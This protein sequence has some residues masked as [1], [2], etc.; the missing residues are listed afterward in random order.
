MMRMRETDIYYQ[1]KYLKTCKITLLLAKVVMDQEL[2]RFYEKKL[3]GARLPAD[4]LNELINS[5]KIIILHFLRHLGC[6]YCKHAVDQLY[7]Y[8]QEHPNFPPVI[9]IHQSNEEQASLFFQ[10]HY[11]D[12]SYITDTDLSLYNLFGIRK[13]KGMHLFD[14]RM[15]FK[16]FKL[17][18]LGYTNRLGHGN[19]Y[20]LSGTFVFLNG[21][22]VWSHR[23]KRAGEEPDWKKVI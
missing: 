7:K 8:K 18:L 15:I 13:L 1:A 14:P 10:K 21:K 19:I 22:M 12:A 2:I 5:N 9:F 16:G 3:E 6:I 20:L 11:P 23:A 17:S 4:T